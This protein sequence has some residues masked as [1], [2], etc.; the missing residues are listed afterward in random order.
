MTETGQSRLWTITP[1]DGAE[2]ITVKESLNCDG[3][4]DDDDLTMV[5]HQEPATRISEKRE[6]VGDRLRTEISYEVPTYEC[7]VDISWYSALDDLTRKQGQVRRGVFSIISLGVVREKTQL[8]FLVDDACRRSGG[9][10]DFGILTCSL[11]HSF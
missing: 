11:D 9:V 7:R 6:N 4:A 3:V 5:P 1:S 8:M 2:Q 10:S